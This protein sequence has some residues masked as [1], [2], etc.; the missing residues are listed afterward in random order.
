M[1]DYYRKQLARG[2]EYQDFVVEQ[3]YNIGLPII[4]YSSK[5]YQTMIG[6]NK[7][8]FEIKFDDRFKDTGNLY[9]E[10]S[11]K[12]APSN[13]TY[14]PSGIFRTDNTWLYLIGNYSR[15]FIFGKRSLI[16]LYESKPSII[17]VVSTPTSN[18]FLIPAKSAEEK[19]ALKILDIKG[20]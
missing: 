14:I 7:C 18:G 17:R 20:A 1:N 16:R 9:I 3:L 15:I 6:E 8:G 4:S 13:P 19:I 11:E 5:K 2:C 10:V 12:S